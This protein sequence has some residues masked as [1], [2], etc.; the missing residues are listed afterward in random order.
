MKVSSRQ[1]H[2]IQM[3][4]YIVKDSQ[5]K[6]CGEKVQWCPVDEY[7]HF[8]TCNRQQIF[9][10]Y[11]MFDYETGLRHSE[12]CRSPSILHQGV[13]RFALQEQA[14]IQDYVPSIAYIKHTPLAVPT[15]AEQEV[16]TRGSGLDF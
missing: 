5:C 13:P 6:D 1:T 2:S 8:I 12:V 16:V 9:K 14:Y 4:K 11:E 7:G 15:V 3:T 10:K